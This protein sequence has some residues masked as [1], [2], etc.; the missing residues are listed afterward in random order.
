MTGRK[1]KTVAYGIDLFIIT[2]AY[3]TGANT[4]IIRLMMM[5]D[6]SFIQYQ[7]VALRYASPQLIYGVVGYYR[8]TTRSI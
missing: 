4:A 6:S 7:H 2:N 3:K 1:L 8:I 5:I